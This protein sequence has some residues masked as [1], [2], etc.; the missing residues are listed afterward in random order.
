MSE[1][2][3]WSLVKDL[4]ADDVVRL[5]YG[6][7]SHYFGVDVGPEATGV[8]LANPF[9]GGM[10]EVGFWQTEM[11]RDMNVAG[12]STPQAANGYSRVQVLAPRPSANG[13]VPFVPCKSKEA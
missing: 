11:D 13:S 4:R 3:E 9:R 6:A 1:Q 2:V 10:P 5:N 8:L 12:E 7:T